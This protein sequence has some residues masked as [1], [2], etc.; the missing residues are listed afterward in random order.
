MTRIT[1]YTAQNVLNYITGRTAMPT[2]PTVYGALF[3]V[4]G[5]D[6]GTGF[7]EVSAGARWS[8]L[9]ISPAF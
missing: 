8:N 5:T 9:F 2:L 4:A 1:A 7:T 3:T 6:S